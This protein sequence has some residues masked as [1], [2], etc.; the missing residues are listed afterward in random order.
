MAAPSRTLARPWSL[1]HVGVS[2]ELPH[3]VVS[4]SEREKDSPPLLEHSTGQKQVT[5]RSPHSGADP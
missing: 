2:P 4:N 5:E 1:C 3:V